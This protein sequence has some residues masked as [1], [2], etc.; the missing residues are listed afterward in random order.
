MRIDHNPYKLRNLNLSAKKIYGNPN[1][2][3][4]DVCSRL[5]PESSESGSGTQQSVWP[6]IVMYGELNKAKEMCV[7][8][9]V[10]RLSVWRLS[11]AKSAEY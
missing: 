11:A 8:F 10:N 5:Q 3:R 1:S 2:G 4:L 7:K 9:L 6:S